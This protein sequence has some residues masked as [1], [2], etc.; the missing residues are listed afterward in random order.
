MPEK[1]AD[2]V[3]RSEARLIR[4]VEGY[5]FP[6]SLTDAQRA[7]ILD[8]VAF[9]AEGTRFAVLPLSDLSV[10]R[11]QLLV[12]DRLLPARAMRVVRESTAIVLDRQQPLSLLV[13][14]DD[15]LSFHAVKPNLCTA[16]VLCAVEEVENI[17]A[18]RIRF[19]YDA[20]FGYLTPSIVD[21]GTGLRISVTLHLPYLEKAGLVQKT[22]ESIKGRVGNA[23]LPFGSMYLLFNSAS[24]GVTEE[25]IALTVSNAALSVIDQERAVRE[26]SLLQDFDTLK[27][28]IENELKNLLAA[29]TLTEKDCIASWSLLRQGVTAGL[30]R[31]SLEKLDA[32]PSAVALAHLEAAAGRTLTPEERGANRAAIFRDFTGVLTPGRL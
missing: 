1:A 7:E 10:Q 21:T 22:F 8:L 24:L 14:G 9:A 17:F 2:V 30:L 26:A 15:P 29:E 27:A 11:K 4:S 16:D 13:N 6:P 12:E 25:E 5:P 31:C 19:S 28:E 20:Q 18:N 23:K 32:L 3:L